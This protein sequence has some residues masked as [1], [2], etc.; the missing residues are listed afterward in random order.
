M[1][2]F[3]KVSLDQFREDFLKCNPQYSRD[4][5]TGEF[6]SLVLDIY[7]KI[8]LPQRATKGSAGYDFYCPYKV[9]LFKNDPVLVPTGIRV[10]MDPGWVLL[11]LPRSGLGFKYRIRLD[12]TAGVIDSDYCNS[13][14]E[15]HIMAKLCCESYDFAA[16]AILKEGQGMMQGVFVQ[17]GVTDNDE[18]LSTT[19]NGGFGSTDAKS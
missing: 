15:G 19:R 1:I 17:Y 16:R 6:D 12:N 8:K 5:N 18:P 3:E 2:K 14:N 9:I 11:I 7:E 13:K 4:A 10:L